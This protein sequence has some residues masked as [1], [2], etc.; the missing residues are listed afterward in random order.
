MATFIENSEK[1]STFCA[2]GG[3]YIYMKRDLNVNFKFANAGQ[4]LLTVFE[5]LAR[6]ILYW[7]EVH[8]LIFL[9]LG[10]GEAKR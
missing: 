10:P 7:N 1:S 6:L 8:I 9:P 4:V 5:I 3:S 2:N